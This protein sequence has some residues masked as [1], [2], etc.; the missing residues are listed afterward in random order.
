MTRVSQMPIGLV[1]RTSTPVVHRDSGMWDR[2]FRAWQA[3]YHWA[4][5]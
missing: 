1:V 5:R 2:V 4:Y 3:R